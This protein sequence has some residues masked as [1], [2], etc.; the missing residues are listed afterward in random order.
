MLHRLHT[1]QSAAE[2][3]AFPWEEIWRNNVEADSLWRTQNGRFQHGRERG[4]G[5]QRASL[6]R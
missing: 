3:S 2:F 4:E 6:R 5:P 1:G